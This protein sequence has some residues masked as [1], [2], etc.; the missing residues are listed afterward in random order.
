MR[1]NSFCFRFISYNTT[2]YNMSKE[3]EITSNHY[4]F[5]ADCKMLMSYDDNN[6]ENNSVN[7]DEE[8]KQISHL[9]EFD[10]DYEGRLPET[11]DELMR[12]PNIDLEEYIEK[13]IE[14]TEKYMEHIDKYL[15]Q[16][17]GNLKTFLNSEISVFQDYS[18]SCFVLINKWYDNFGCVTEKNKKEILN[19]LFNKN[20]K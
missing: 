1:T 5:K 9:N 18:H 3:Y 15:Y 13:V 20:I 7:Y 16:I 2:Y 19:S 14:R 8:E 12:T 4:N 11:K 10:I 6:F 17:E